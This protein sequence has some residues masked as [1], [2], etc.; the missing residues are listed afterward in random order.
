[1]FNGLG[2]GGVLIS[3]DITVATPGG[4][5]VY[6]AAYSSSVVSCRARSINANVH[7][8]RNRCCPLKHKHIAR[9]EPSF[10]SCPDYY[11]NWE[12]RVNCN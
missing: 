10:P 9:T 7:V 11:F 3:D 8:H 2:S 1:M 6:Q 12:T 5:N 4:L